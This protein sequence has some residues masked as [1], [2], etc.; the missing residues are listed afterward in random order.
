MNKSSCRISHLTATK[1][2]ILIYKN[3]TYKPNRYTLNE[4]TLNVPPLL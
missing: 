3:L 2:L 4:L 1:H